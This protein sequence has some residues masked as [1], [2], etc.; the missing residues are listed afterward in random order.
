MMLIYTMIVWF[1]FVGGGGV[2]RGKIYV[3]VRTWG[4][5]FWENWQK[6]QKNSKK[7]KLTMMGVLFS[8]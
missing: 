5:I 1:L 8:K 7:Q 3:F 2:E 4:R 6:M